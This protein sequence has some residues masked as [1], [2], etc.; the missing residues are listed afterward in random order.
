M[1]RDEKYTSSIYNGYSVRILSIH[2]EGCDCQR[3]L[4][5]FGGYINHRQNKQDFMYMCVFKHTV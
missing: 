4:N 5:T 2:F 3:S 1:L